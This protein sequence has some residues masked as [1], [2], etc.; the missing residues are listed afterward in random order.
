MSIEV[1]FFNKDSEQYQLKLA[2]DIFAEI[3]QQ[4][5]RRYLND[6]DIELDYITFDMED[7]DLFPKGHIISSMRSGNS[8]AY[9]V[10]VAVVGADNKFTEVLRCKVWSMSGAKDVLNF[11]N[12]LMID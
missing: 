5:E 3:K 10:S 6:S 11:I 7:E 4:L 8:E 9:I 12:D 2:K 1:D